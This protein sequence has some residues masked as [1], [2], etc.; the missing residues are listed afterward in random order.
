[1]TPLSIMSLAGKIPKVI[2]DVE[3]KVKYFKGI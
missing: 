1:M 2:Q 3:K